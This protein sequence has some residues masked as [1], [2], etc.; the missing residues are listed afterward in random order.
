MKESSLKFT[1]PSVTH[2]VFDINP[3]CNEKDSVSITN[4]F[5]VEVSKSKDKDENEAVVQLNII[6]GDKDFSK[7]VPFYFDIT[8]G[9]MFSWDDAYDDETLQTLLS[10]NAPALLLGYARPI[11]ANITESSPIPAYHMPFYNFTE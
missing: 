4:T 1:N 8:I 5:N 11:I 10:K 3:E 9:A 7:G 6:I 2:L